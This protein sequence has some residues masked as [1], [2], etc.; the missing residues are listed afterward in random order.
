MGICGWG[1]ATFLVDQCSVASSCPSQVMNTRE[2]F[3][4]ITDA[5]ITNDNIAEYLEVL[6]TR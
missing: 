6:Q 3:D 4:F 2:L 1:K 5:N